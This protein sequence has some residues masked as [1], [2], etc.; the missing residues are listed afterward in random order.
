[1]WLRLTRKRDGNW[2]SLIFED[3]VEYRTSLVAYYMALNI[4][5]LATTIASGKLSTF[6]TSSNPYFHI[7]LTFLSEGYSISQRAI[8]LL[9]RNPEAL[10]ILWASV[11]VTREQMAS[12]W[13]EWTRLCGNELMRYGFPFDPMAHQFLTDNYQHLFEVL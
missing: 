8:S 12:S 2:L 5:E 7:P 11:N 10:S 9:I 1:M 13:P 4:Y 3:D 6:S